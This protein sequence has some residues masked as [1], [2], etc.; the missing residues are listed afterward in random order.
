MIRLNT[1]NGML[2]IC[3]IIASLFVGCS[4]DDNAN[5]M[6]TVSNID[7]STGYENEESE[8]YTQLHIAMFTLSD[9]PD[10]LLVQDAVNEILRERINAEVRIDFIGIG[11]YTQKTN[12]MLSLNEPLDL[13]PTLVNPSLASYVS[14]GQFLP[15]DDLLDEYGQ[16]I[17]EN[18]PDNY[19]DYG[20]IDG[21]IY[22]ITT[23]RDLAKSYGFTF[24]KDLA[25]KHGIQASDI[26]T[27]NDIETALKIIKENESDMYPLAPQQR[28]Y[29]TSRWGTFDDLG[30]GNWLGVLMYEG[31]ALEIV[32]YYESDEFRNFIYET[33]SW[34]DDGLIMPYILMNTEPGSSLVKP[35]KH[36]AIYRIPNQ[37]LMYRKQEQQVWI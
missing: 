30:D 4:A 31:T 33:K 35:A 28:S 19:I 5:E 24:R 9:S 14:N 23:N 25:E 8:D 22:G 37:D 1:L 18:I 2:S 17:L 34:Y 32:N 12:L 3:V 7:E 36:L 26:K 16:G 20:R 6:E 21:R 29:I 27:L 10:A 15:L 11:S 13:M